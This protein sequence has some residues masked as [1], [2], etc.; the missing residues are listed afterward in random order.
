METEGSR[1]LFGLPK[2]AV[3]GAAQDRSQLFPFTASLT[4]SLLFCLVHWTIAE[5]GL[6][7]KQHPGGSGSS[8]SGFAPAVSESSVC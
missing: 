5:C 8:G 1:I 2:T 6:R 3:P 7:G 4:V